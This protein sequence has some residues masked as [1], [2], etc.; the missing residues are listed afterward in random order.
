MVR[1]EPYRAGTFEKSGPNPSA[2]VRC[3]IT[4]SRSFGYGRFASIAVCTAA[5]TSPASEP[6]I[7]SDEYL[8]KALSVVR[9]FRAQNGTHRQPRDAR[10]QPSALCLALAHPD[11]GKGRVGEHAIGNQ[12][13]AR[14]AVPSGQVVPDD[15]KIIDRGMRELRAAGAFADRPDIG[16]GRLQLLV[17]A[18]VTAS[19]QLDAGLLEPDLGVVRKAP[20]RDQDVGTP[21]RPLTGSR[22]HGNA[23]L[24]AGAAAHVEGLGRH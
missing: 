11:M 22:A 18:D 4:A 6:V 2:I 19:V 23:D 7:V 3:A 21:D 5:M 24:L 10:D 9:G 1:R 14:A 8:H 12:P 13:I 15:A 16:R 20:R 17:D